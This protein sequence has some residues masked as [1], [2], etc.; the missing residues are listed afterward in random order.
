MR[1][2]PAP[3]GQPEGMRKNCPC[4][5]QKPP[6]G[7]QGSPRRGK[8]R[9]QKGELILNYTENYHLN[10]WDATDRVLMEDFNADN[11]KIDTAIA[12]IPYV[13]IKELTLSAAATTASL[14]V[15][16]VDFSQYMKIELFV[17]APQSSGA[18]TVQVNNLTSG[19][20]ALSVDGNGSGLGTALSAQY[21][22]TF[23]K[24]GYGVLLFYTP[25]PG[26]KVGCVNIT[27][28]ESS[29]SGCQYFAP[30]TWSQLKNF[31]FKITGAS[32]PAGSSFVLCGVKA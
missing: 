24:Y 8:N 1:A 5:R 21:L 25:N 29:F 28:T 26:G 27:A 15:S 9:L 16:D 11:E 31:N 10:Q 19:Y 18:I 30:C 7:R 6:P 20:S 2:F 3:A 23:Y 12:A 17:H 32:F 13:K 22:A 4:F 14:D